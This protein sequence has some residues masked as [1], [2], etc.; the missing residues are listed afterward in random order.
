MKL[1]E[2]KV[3]KKDDVIYINLRGKIDTRTV[4]DFKEVLENV[5]S[6]SE[7]TIVINYKDVD[8]VS[9]AG[10]GALLRFCVYSK[11]ENKNVIVTGMK[12][13]IKN[14]FDIMEL[15]RFIEYKEDLSIPEFPE[16]VEIEKKKEPSFKLEKWLEE[17]VV[18]NP[19][20]EPEELF[21]MYEKIDKNI[22][23]EKFKSLLREKKLLTREDRLIFAYMKLKEK[24]LK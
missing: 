12:P 6:K 1:F 18:E 4:N 24:L 11:K 19:L 21:K 2:A 16:E 8:Y 22:S 5:K 15:Y 17:K 3:F 10:Y 14:I 9:S 23:L 20:L 13:E 7:G